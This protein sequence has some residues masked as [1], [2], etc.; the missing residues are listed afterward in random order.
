MKVLTNMGMSQQN[1]KAMGNR[2]EELLL[3]RLFRR[4][5]TILRPDWVVIYDDRVIIFEVKAKT[6]RFKPPPFE[7][8][9]LDNKQITKYQLLS[10]K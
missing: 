2:A 5:Y 10:K 8:H 7:G 1:L 9:G 4:G 6:E 3:S